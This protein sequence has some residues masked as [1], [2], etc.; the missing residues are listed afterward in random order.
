LELKKL[1]KITGISYDLLNGSKKYNSELILKFS[2]EFKDVIDNIEKRFR[3]RDEGNKI[4]IF[5]KIKK[6]MLKFGNIQ[7]EY[8]TTSNYII[9]Q[10][11]NYIQEN[12]IKY[13]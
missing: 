6:D 9:T 2:T 13:E 12:Y 4:K 5:E 8:L 11:D 3:K 1:S 10:I 7:P